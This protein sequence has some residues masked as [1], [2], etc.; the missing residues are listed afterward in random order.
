MYQSII[1]IRDKVKAA[2][3]NQIK[4]Y[5]LD[6]PRLIAISSLP[7]ISVVPI[8]TDI[9]IADTERDVYRY[10]ID[11][12]LIINAL[13]QLDSPKQE[14]VGM[15]YLTKMMEEKEFDGSLKAN[16]ILD[17]LRNDM[18]IDDN[19]YIENISSIDYTVRVRS[20]QSVTLESWARITVV[21]FINR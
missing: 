12:Y 18:T 17:A 7:C 20:E 1:K 13:T 14:M 15:Q 3:G 4:T 5:F 19:W 21:R 9:D 11:V 6:D 2:L 16:T 10:T 8:R